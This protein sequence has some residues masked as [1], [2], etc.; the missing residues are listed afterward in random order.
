[1]RI[2]TLQMNCQFKRCTAIVLQ[3]PNYVYHLSS[4]CDWCPLP[5]SSY[6]TCLW[7]CFNYKCVLLRVGATQRLGENDLLTAD[8]MDKA[9]EETIKK[10]IYPVC[11]L[12]KNLWYLLKT[13]YSCY[14]NNLDLVKDATFEASNIFIVFMLA[15]QFLLYFVCWIMDL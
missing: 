2:N 15:C 4:L 12:P 7:I 3:P 5:V 6:S 9:D 1:M 13:I 14:S 11:S 8:A 10:L